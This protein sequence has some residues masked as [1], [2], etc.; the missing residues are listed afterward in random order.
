MMFFGPLLFLLFFAFMSA[1]VRDKTANVIGTVMHWIALYQP[2]SYLVV[3][4]VILAPILSGFLV[5][6]WPRTP[7]PENPLLRYK[8]EHFDM[9]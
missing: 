5:A 9:D 7:E 8:N 6:Y 1:T 4:L 2:M 3:M